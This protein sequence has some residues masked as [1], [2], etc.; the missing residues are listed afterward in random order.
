MIGVLKQQTRKL[1][2]RLLI[3]TALELNDGI[4]R[5]PIVAPAPGI[6]FRMIGRA[7]TYVRV[8]PDQAQE[9]PYLLLA[10]I[11]IAPFPANPVLGN[12]VTQPLPRPPHD[13]DMFRQQTNF[14]LEFTEHCLFGGFPLLDAPLRELP[15]MLSNT[16]APENLVTAVGEDNADVRA[17]TFPIQHDEPSNI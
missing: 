13:A 4:Q 10:T 11:G 9:K 6:E 17:K 16:F 14:L 2:Q 5:H 3:D 8:P 1:S 12:L 7:Q 15:G